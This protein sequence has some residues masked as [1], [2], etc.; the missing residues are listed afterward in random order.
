MRDPSEPTAT[1][2]SGPGSEASR[3]DHWDAAYADADADHSWDQA[4]ATRSLRLLGD[5]PDGSLPATVI[6]V[7]GGTSPLAAALLEGGVEVTVLDVSARALER[8]GQAIGDPALRLD[9]VV[10]DVARWTPDRR[11]DGWH[12]RA[13][14]HFLTDPDDRAAYRDRLHAAVVPGGRVVLATFATDGPDRCS[15]LPTERYDGPDLADHLG[16]VDV[17]VEREVHRTPWGTE[18]P[19]TWVAGRVPR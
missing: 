4:R 19:F 14:F 6:D 7:G 1:P 9:L 3:R 5:G 12:D 8:L 17:E 11:Y 15:G 13:V 2:D 10:A 16:L 18:Q